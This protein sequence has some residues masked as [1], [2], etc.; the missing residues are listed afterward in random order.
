M[1]A[2]RYGQGSDYFSYN[3]ILKQIPTLSAAIHNTNNVHSEI[4]FRILCSLFRGNFK[5]FIFIVS[6]FEMYM[7]H[8]CIS[9]YSA[10][11]LLSLIL[12][13]PTYYLTYY[14]SAIRQGIVLAIFLGILLPYFQQ[15]KWIQYYVITFIAIT[16][17]SMAVI[18]IVIPFVKLFKLK[19]FLL[20]LLPS[21]GM[22]MFMVT[23]FGQNLLSKVPL[24]SYY[25]SDIG[26]SWMG[27]LE[28]VIML[29]GILVLSFLRGTKENSAE[30]NDWIKI[31]VL[32]MCIYLALLPYALIAS[33][34]MMIFKV[35]EVIIYPNLFSDIKKIMKYIAILLILFASV[36]TCKNLNSYI[37]QG[38]YY[39]NVEFYNYPYISIF[40]ADKIREYRILPKYYKFIK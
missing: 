7:L 32:G 24:V 30:T 19:H 37:E 9:K 15:N 18:L 33:R 2:F 39:R 21:M 12:F 28:R 27:M 16:I 14:F 35:L 20:M 8:R 10:N 17:H 34:L 6:I 40:N 26:V 38:D 22:G 4:G 29:V 1:L 23:D 5:L 11:P 13:Y 31:N 3:Y 25:A 36:M